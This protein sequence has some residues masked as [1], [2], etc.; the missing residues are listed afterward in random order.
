MAATG[1]GAGPIGPGGSETITVDVL[2]LAL[3]T[4]LISTSTMLVNTND[5]IT[6]L[7]SL[8]VS[9]MAPGDVLG[10]RTIAYDAGTEADSEEA[11]HIPGPAG[12]GEG[13]NSAR[14]DEA[15]RE[16]MHSGVVG[17]DDGFPTSDLA[18]HHRFDDPV[19]M[20]RIERIN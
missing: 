12:G 19:A 8:P 15:D 18:N 17:G 13:F 5:A 9:G 11:R 16:S 1:S 3:P 4:L 10:M 20:V 6:V 7:D 14:D 2:E